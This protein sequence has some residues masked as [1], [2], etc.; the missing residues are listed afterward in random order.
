MSDER[1]GEATGSGVC[2]LQRKT[3]LDITVA[4]NYKA[5]TRDGHRSY[6][7]RSTAEF[8]SWTLFSLLRVI[9]LP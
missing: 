4:T 5:R 8:R 6:Y 7:V 9:S 1:R 3:K 2:V